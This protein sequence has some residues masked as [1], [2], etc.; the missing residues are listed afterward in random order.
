MSAALE[1][2]ETLRRGMVSD[3]AHELRTPLSNIRGYMEGLR[4]GVIAPEP[5]LFD[6][7]HEQAMILNR[8]VGDLQEL[9][10]AEAGQL[11]LELRPAR[12]GDIVRRAVSVLGAEASRHGVALVADLPGDL[13]LVCADSARVGQML[14]NLLKN[15]IMYTPPGGH[16]V[17]RAY[18]SGDGVTVLVR[19][20]GGGIPAEAL[21]H[22]FERFYRVD[23]SRARATGGSGLGLAIVKQLAQAQGGTVWAESALGRGSTFAFTLPKAGGEATSA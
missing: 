5:K 4:D 12:V 16:V 11:A 3:I 17:I 7:L 14:L 8:L 23:R 20:S 21:P 1:R 22:V 13:P 9:A 18:A 19:D 10:L 15:A 6:A 2:A